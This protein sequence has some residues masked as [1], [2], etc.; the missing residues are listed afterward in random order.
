MT[1]PVAWRPD[2]TPHSPLFGDIYRSVGAD[3]QGGLAQARHVFLAG[4]GLWP[5]DTVQAAPATSAS[6]FTPAQPSPAAPSPAPSPEPSPL[7]A[8]RPA[9]GPIS[10]TPDAADPREA[11]HSSN[12]EGS[13]PLTSLSEKRESTHT[14]WSD[15]PH[16]HVLETGF[17]LGLN[18]LATWAAWR[19]DPQRPARLFFTSIEAHPVGA[20]DLLRSA[21][22]FPEL[23]DLAAQLAAQWQAMLPGVH[24]LVFEGGA[25]QLTL[26]VGDVR[27]LLREIDVAVDSVFLDGFSP[28]LNPEMWDLP[29]IKGV[30]RLARP[31]TRVAT[32]TVARALRDHLQQCGFVLERRPGLPP[33]RD[34]LAARYA[35]SWVPRHLAQLRQPLSACQAADRHAVVV[36]AG[37]SGASVAASLAAR[38]WRVTVLDAAATPAAGASGL[39]AGIFAP[40][41]SPDDGRLAQLTRAGVRAM[42][43]RCADL[44]VPGQDW[45]DTGVLE[46]PVGR[47]RRLPAA[48]REAALAHAAHP[49]LDSSRPAQP[50]D[51]PQW[52]ADVARQRL[53]A[54]E[55]LWHVQAGWVRPAQ[56]VR[57]QL[58]L[59]GVQWRGGCQVTR[60]SWHDP[61]SPPAAA[62]GTTAPAPQPAAAHAAHA[63]SAAAPQGTGPGLAAP[64]GSP[65]TAPRRPPW[66]LFNEQGQ[67]LASADLV[68]LAAGP[69][70][71][72]LVQPW[73]A[74]AE[75]PTHRVQGLVTLGRD[76]ELDAPGTASDPADP[77]PAAANAA[78]TP[79]VNGHGSLLRAIPGDQ[80]A[81]WCTGAS[82]LRELPR[83]FDAATIA[84]EHQVNLDRLDEL[85]PVTAQRARR[86]WRAGQVW[87]W[88][89]ARCTVADRVPLVGP[90][91]APEHTTRTPRRSAAATPL[92]SAQA[93]HAASD[94]PGDEVQA[95]SLQAPWVC[96]AMGARGLT[97]AVLSGELLAA[98]LHGEPLPI[99]R[100][101][102]QQLAAHRF[103][104]GD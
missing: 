81:F 71:A 54:S 89:G 4:C 61:A 51:A 80:G 88:H 33:K 35:P 21:Q 23:H 102:A 22:P 57:A 56:L 34:C 30:A 100:S 58:A 20:A 2:G 46:L 3:G 1:S 66:S 85:L 43:R 69:A 68:V 42:R 31:G 5:P 49:G 62:P 86:L 98:W 29:V 39:P 55:P 64:A 16:W 11:T 53:L 92:S 8:S 52:Q 65:A 104:A 7:A 59:P 99:A 60:L 18:F 25:V 63:A 67:H 48:W 40:H 14:A 6:R 76:S 38:G 19:A 15:H 103:M 75:F 50:D 37:I 47:E 17:G 74:P 32:W 90:L 45:A 94:S 36:G 27:P 87:H 28:R 79:P 13:T 24:R 70:T 96:T 44:L 12:V 91:Q 77:Q 83:G 78:P 84:A 101:L 10:Q 73:C 72:A 26:C 95:L 41:V 97:L 93:G 9:P 82:F